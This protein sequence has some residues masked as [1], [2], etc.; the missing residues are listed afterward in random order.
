MPVCGFSGTSVSIEIEIRK[1]I[2]NSG[3]VFCILFRKNALWKN[4]NPSLSPHPL[5]HSIARYT[6]ITNL[7]WQT[8][9]F[10]I[11]RSQRE[12]IPLFYPIMQINS[13]MI[14]KRNSWCSMIALRK[15]ILFINA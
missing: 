15:M 2:S 7:E 5:L 4:I 13:Q 11:W 14:K 8:V 12:I 10:K 9:K 1:P 6:G 3:L